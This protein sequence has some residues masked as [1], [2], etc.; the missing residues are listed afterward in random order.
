M[1]NPKRDKGFGS[2]NT[3]HL[4]SLFFRPD[5]AEEFT[6]TEFE[7][8]KVTGKNRRES[9][10]VLAGERLR[11]FKRA[12]SLGH[13]HWLPRGMVLKNLILEVA[14]QLMR[15][16][17]AATYDFSH[18]FRRLPGDDPVNSLFEKFAG[19]IFTFGD[20]AN[21]QYLRYAT[22]P[23][24]FDMLSGTSIVTPLRTYSPGYFFRIEDSGA[25]KPLTRPREFLM[26]D[27]HFMAE[28]ESDFAEFAHAALLNAVAM[29]YWFDD[30]SWWLNIDTNEADFPHLKAPLLALL[31]E[32]G[33]RAKVNVTSSA[34]HYYSL[35]FQYIGRFF[36]NNATQIANLQFDRKNGERFKILGQHSGRPVTVIHGTIFGRVEKIVAVL[37]GAAIENAEASK[38]KPMLPVWLNPVLVRVIP[39][40]KEMVESSVYRELVT[41][42]DA[43]GI[44]YELDLR[45]EGLRKKIK[46][47]E[48]DWMPYTVVLGENEVGANECSVRVRSESKQVSLQIEELIDIIRGELQGRPNVPNCVGTSYQRI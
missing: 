44:R 5:A 18:V 25:V 17:G 19:E 35:Q 33:C 16:A 11:L 29:R 9:E 41:A 36:D 37:L 28:R 12:A 13:L 32:I 24:L 46:Q 34:T 27:F 38:S 10:L 4:Y 6:S 43:N 45:D 14:S 23:I 48:Q 21:L 2:K 30:S 1:P 20:A 15:D 31:Q 47:A 8:L 40:S 7:S 3:E 22:D 39:M 26:T 42:L